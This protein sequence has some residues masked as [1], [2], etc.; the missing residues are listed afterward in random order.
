MYGLREVGYEE[1]GFGDDDDDGLRK[2]GNE[3]YNV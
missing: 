3:G 2:G 1:Y